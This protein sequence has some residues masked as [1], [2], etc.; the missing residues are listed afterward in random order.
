MITVIIEKA[1]PSSPPPLLPSLPPPPP[2][3]GVHALLSGLPPLLLPP[4]GEDEPPL[5]GAGLC[6]HLGG[7]LGLLRSR[8]LLRLLLQRCEC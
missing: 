1:S 6:R 7:H 2:P 3:A 8:H 4:L 5:A